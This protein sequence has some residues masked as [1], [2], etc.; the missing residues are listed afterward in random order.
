MTT[1]TGTFTGTFEG[2]F[3]GDGQPPDR[4]GIRPPDPEQ[5]P[6]ESG[7]PPA[8]PPVPSDAIWCPAG[9]EPADVVAS[10]P[11][12]GTLVIEDGRYT[13]SIWVSTEGL[14]I[15]S[16]SGNP[17]ACWFD[18]QGGE[19]GGHQLAA[20]KGMV[21]SSRSIN[22]I[23]IGF[24]NCGSPASGENYSNEAAIWV[25]DT[26][27]VPVQALA[28]RCAFDNCAN[29]C[30]TPWEPATS[31][32]VAECLFGYIAP[33]G[34]NASLSGQNCGPAHDNYLQCGEVEVSHSYFWG[35]SNGHNVKSRAGETW[36]H[37]NPCMTQDGGRAFEAT[38]GGEAFFD[39][40][41][42]YTRTD[43]PGWQHSNAN[44]L[45]YC[46]ENANAGAGTLTM[47]GN[48]L[49]ISRN[50]ST[51]WAAAGAIQASGDTVHYYGEGS[52]QLQGNVQG[53]DAG[54]APPGSPPAPAL[55][56]PPSWAVP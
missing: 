8:I 30:F 53:I 25:G 22:V 9:Q 15:R 1:F 28:Q 12:G 23:G 7:S 55:P 19:G 33:N 18:G 4:P 45:A 50:G 13:R 51:I 32:R 17:Y 2:T 46:A 48:T 20:H 16:A 14:T 39:N 44:L 10:V 43:R 26:E 47:S 6:P 5:P 38:E 35:C 37:D 40:N 3:T 52:L 41:V 49:H 24:R 54:Q 21:L 29:G 11:P 31:F 34:Q 56:E 42:V 36:A 27:G